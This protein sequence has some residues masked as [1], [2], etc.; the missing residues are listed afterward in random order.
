MR[1]HKKSRGLILKMLFLAVCAS[2]ATTVTYSYDAGGRMTQV[3]FGDQAQIS[4]AYDDN[5]NLLVREVSV[6]GVVTY[7]LIYTAGMGGTISG[8][9]TQVVSSGGS[10]TPV[11]AV[12]NLYFQFTQWNDGNTNATRIDSNI[13]SNQSFSAQF[14]GLQAE[15]GTPL[16]WLAENGYTND[17]NAAENSD[18]DADGFTAKQ[19][20]IAGTDP[21]NPA[22]LFE[23][24]LSPGSGVPGVSWQSVSGRV[25]SVWQ[26]TNLVDW[27]L[28]DGQDNITG[29]G[30]E[31]SI[32]PD[33]GSTRG[34]FR[35]NVQSP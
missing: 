3:A 35:I 28:M 14:F 9:A 15:Q 17:M 16:W 26:S 7:T 12:T 20:Y 6:T 27:V 21:H 23:V 32:A 31:K 24:G 13:T 25:Y 22:S 29:D 1:C 5:G 2:H 34:Y 19:E 4:Y 30:T 11:T 33:S 18:D 10:G 8:S